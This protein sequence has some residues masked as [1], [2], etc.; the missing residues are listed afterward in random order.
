MADYEAFMNLKYAKRG[1]ECL[2]LG[3]NGQKWLIYGL[4][5]LTIS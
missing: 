3:G 5:G 1:R 2:K 4:V